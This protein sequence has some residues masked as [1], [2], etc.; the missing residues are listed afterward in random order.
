MV[1][2]VT[3]SIGFEPWKSKSDNMEEIMREFSESSIAC[4]VYKDG[5]GT[6]KLEIKTASAKLDFLKRELGLK[7]IFDHHRPGA[8]LYFVKNGVL[9]QRHPV[10][11]KQLEY[12]KSAEQ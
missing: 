10:D 11:G 5:K 6:D 1:I 2:Q 8:L 7:V 4:C 12:L 9:D 3:Y